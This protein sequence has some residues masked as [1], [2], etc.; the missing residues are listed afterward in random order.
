MAIYYKTY[1]NVKIIHV[2]FT[3]I[4]LLIF[5]LKQINV[6]SINIIQ[7]SSFSTKYTN[8]YHHCFSQLHHPFF[9]HETLITLLGSF[10]IHYIIFMINVIASTLKF[11]FSSLNLFLPV[12]FHRL[13]I[14][15]NSLPTIF[16]I[17]NVELSVKEKMK[18]EILNS[19]LFS[20]GGKQ[21]KKHSNCNFQLVYHEP[22]TF[23]SVNFQQI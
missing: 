3:I 10:F 8:Y 5:Q 15:L 4:N 19:H 1:H 22:L 21:M 2:S 16:N 17:F 13:Q 7:V 18:V 11:N 20:F 12:I 14:R 23:P 9:P 6:N